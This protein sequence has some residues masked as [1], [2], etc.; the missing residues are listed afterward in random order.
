MDNVACN[1]GSFFSCSKRAG[2]HGSA[3][4]PDNLS[5]ALSGVSYG[6]SRRQVRALDKVR[7]LDSCQPAVTDIHFGVSGENSDSDGW[8]E[9]TSACLEVVQEFLG[10]QIAPV[11]PFPTARVLPS[12]AEQLLVKQMLG[13]ALAYPSAGRSSPFSEKKSLS[14]PSSAVHLPRGIT[15]VSGDNHRLRGVIA[16]TGSPV[17]SQGVAVVRD[18]SSC[19]EATQSQSVAI[20]TNNA[21]SPEVTQGQDAPITKNNSPGPDP[22]RTSKPSPVAVLA[23]W[24][25]DLSKARFAHSSRSEPQ[26]KSK[27][28]SVRPHPY[29]QTATRNSSHTDAIKSSPSALA[30]P[31]KCSAFRQF[32]RQPVYFPQELPRSQRASN[33][34]SMSV[35]FT[36]SPIDLND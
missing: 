36:E 33:S 23:T 4:A 32:L 22:T 12:K 29:V 34:G 19:P 5:D 13:D 8:G 20:P 24:L 1:S 28:R 18:N 3:G 17:Q 27:R 14:L 31:G 6:G 11:E 16:N 2:H 7:V 10:T 25:N 21:V 35:S 9:P 30:G 26:C 15:R